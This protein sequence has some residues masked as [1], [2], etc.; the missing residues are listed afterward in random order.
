MAEREANRG[1]RR[2]DGR[3]GGEEARVSGGRE[4]EGWG[5]PG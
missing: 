4:E 2:E 3:G 1:E 5:V